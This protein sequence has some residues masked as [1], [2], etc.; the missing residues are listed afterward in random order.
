M[1]VVTA[2]SACVPTSARVMAPATQLANAS[3]SR[4]GLELTATLKP[5]LCSAQL[6]ANALTTNVI[7]SVVGLVETVQ[8]LC[9]I[10]GAVAMESV[11]PQQ[12]L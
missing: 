8:L 1:L 3:A 10:R 12:A 5:A 6:T 9:V 4:D 11:S 7:V 2:P